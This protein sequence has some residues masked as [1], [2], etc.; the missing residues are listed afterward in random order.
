M[1]IYYTSAVKTDINSSNYILNRPYCSDGYIP[2][3][4]LLADTYTPDTQSFTTV[5]NV[6]RGSCNSVAY[7]V[8]ISESV[9]SLNGVPSRQSPLSIIDMLRDIPIPIPI[10]I[11]IPPQL[12]GNAISDIFNSVLHDADTIII[13][14]DSMLRT[15]RESRHKGFMRG[16]IEEDIRYTV[17]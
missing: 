16:C 7:S 10:Y 3:E 5:S 11:P 17:Q 9:S 1:P 4:Q 6:R 12:K 2:I 13:R 14:C 15:V 8:H